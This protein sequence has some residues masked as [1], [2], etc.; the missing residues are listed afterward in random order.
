MKAITLN[1]PDIGLRV[2]YTYYI[3]L[4][5]HRSYRTTAP[6][7]GGRGGGT[8]MLGAVRWVGVSPGLTENWHSRWIYSRSSVTQTSSIGLKLWSNPQRYLP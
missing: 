7:L 5:R 1:V 8:N 3:R 2:I 4:K 6:D